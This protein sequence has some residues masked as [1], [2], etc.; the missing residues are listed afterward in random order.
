MK[1]VV[2]L[3]QALT[4]AALA[5]SGY[6]LRVS[7]STSPLKHDRKDFNQNL[8]AH[9][10]LILAV[11]PTVTKSV[12]PNCVQ[13]AGSDLEVALPE[14]FTVT[15][16]VQGS[17]STTQLT[18][19][20]H[21]VFALDSSSSMRR[22]DPDDLRIAASVQFVD[23]L[24]SSRGDRAGVVSWDR[25]IDISLPLTSNFQD[26]KNALNQVDDCCGTRLDVGLKE[27]VEIMGPRDPT[28]SQVIIFLTGMFNCIMP[29]LARA[30]LQLSRCILN[31]ATL[32][33]PL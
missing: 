23:K 24:S 6:A 30:F 4:W 2:V 32:L 13:Q 14:E 31:C 25:D 22:T 5:S 26:V 28:V 17:G 3:I 8:Q 27:A 15:L 7:S 19:P 12:A 21:V 11:P 18:V 16:S 1:I 9:R 10:R 33:F 29:A 20:V